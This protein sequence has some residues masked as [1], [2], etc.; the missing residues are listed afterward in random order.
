MSS[1]SSHSASVREVL[2]QAFLDAPMFPTR[3]R[4]NAQRAPGGPAVAGRQTG[5]AAPAADGR[6]GPDRRG[7]PRSARLP[8]E[9]RRRPG[10]S[11]PSPRAPDHPGLPGRGDGHRRARG[12]AGPHRGGR[13]Q[14]PG[15]RSAGSVPIG[16]RGHYR[17]TLRLSRSRATRGAAYARDPHQ[18]LAGSPHCRRPR[19]A[20]RSRHR[21]GAARI[22]ATGARRGRAPRRA[23]AA[24]LSHRIGGTTGRSRKPGRNRE[25][26][27]RTGGGARVERSLRRPGGA[28]ARHA[29]VAYGAGRAGDEPVGGRGAHPRA[30]CGLS[31]GAL[32]AAARRAGATAA[33]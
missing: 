18:P 33:P 11:G 15:S 24:R 30:P 9:Y 6:G 5:A 16:A 29:D 27:G 1:S 25:R 8:G 32:R 14:P 20:R 4:W 10:D 13:R 21:Q 31:R 26:G 3:W 7:L 17:S 23:H 22:L 12:P 19:Q 2:I 28:A